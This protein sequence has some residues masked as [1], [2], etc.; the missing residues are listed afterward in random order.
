MKRPEYGPGFDVLTALQT[1]LIEPLYKQVFRVARSMIKQQASRC[2]SRRLSCLIE[3]HYPGFFN[4]TEHR[5]TDGRSHL[6][7]IPARVTILG[8]IVLRLKLKDLQRIRKVEDC[9]DLR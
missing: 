6:P 2:I 8:E 1:A 4:V 5:A 7:W 3:L 9:S